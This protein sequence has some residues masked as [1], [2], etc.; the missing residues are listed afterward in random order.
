MLGRKRIVS[1]CQQ[2][3]NRKR[4]CDGG[5]PSCDYCLKHEKDCIYTARR[6]RG[7]GKGKEATKLPIRQHDQGNS[8]TELDSANVVLSDE[9]R[10]HEGVEGNTAQDSRR[11]QTT[12]TQ[13]STNTSIQSPCSSS[14]VTRTLPAAVKR[15]TAFC[16]DIRATA[17]QTQAEIHAKQGCSGNKVFTRLIPEYQAAELIGP[18]IEEIQLH[19]VFLGKESTLSQLAEQYRAGVDDSCSNP[20]RWATLCSFM[21]ISMLHRTADG[22]VA[23]LSFIAWAFFKNAF[24]MFTDLTIQRP[25]ISTCEVLLAMSLF[26]LRNADAC[27]ATRLT[28]FAA[29][30]VLMLG[31]HKYEHYLNLEVSEAERQRRIFWVTFVV[32]TDVAH[33]CGLPSPLGIEDVDV[34][35]PGNGHHN[36]SSH[37]DHMEDLAQS[38]RANFLRQRAILAVT[39]LRIHKTLQ[40]VLSWNTK[41]KH[42][43]IH[44]AIEEISEELEA[45]KCSL[46]ITIQPGSRSH[47]SLLLEM[48]IAMLH[49]IYFSCI[50]KVNMAL[51]LLTHPVPV[52]SVPG[53][54][55]AIDLDA[56]FSDS[57]LAKVRCATAA[58]EILDVLFRLQ[59]QPFTHLWQTLCFPLSAVLILLSE[60]LTNPA[61]VQAETDAE[62]IYDF[63]RYLERLQKKG[64]SVRELLDG[65]RK[66]CSIATCALEVSKSGEHA[67]TFEQTAE[68][69]LLKLRFAQV[70]DWLQLAEGLLSNMPAPQD[71][72]REIF[73]DIL[74]SASMD[75][76][77]GAFVPEY[78]KS[79]T[80]NLSF[81][82]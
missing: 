24:A 59:P 64:S 15:F 55:L 74:S 3:K 75:D 48:P 19:G 63:V 35:F 57:R 62:L 67:N 33:R 4:R 39:Q 44:E 56:S 16:E 76:P 31:L 8:S 54:Q 6:R 42:S 45:W 73:R 52:N 5:E 72:A 65:C 82:N 66:L 21:G 81:G 79:S 27:A 32:N 20:C 28:A 68:I 23:T 14:E 7:P 10:G 17:I 46:H 18:V 1:A 34:D 9:S 22:S 11:H 36:S 47:E 80:F 60:V 13:N 25:K 12:P 29:Q 70:T 43:D 41:R 50:S 69:R 30:S 49:Y 37:V 51:V 58:R 77:Y 61:S 2:C 40:Q 53:E 71:K 26:M 78:L 38:Q